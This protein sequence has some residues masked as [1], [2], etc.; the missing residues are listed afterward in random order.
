MVVK[1]F[2]DFPPEKKLSAAKVRLIKNPN[3][4]RL[5]QIKR[6]IP[7][8]LYLKLTELMNDPQRNK[9]A[10]RLVKAIYRSEDVSETF[11]F[12]ACNEWIF[13]T[14]KSMEMI[15]ILTDREKETFELDV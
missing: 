7:A 5:Y 6:R 15:S 11:S 10:N 3:I 1:Y 9:Q 8:L 12:F 2:N 4:I 13:E 14:K